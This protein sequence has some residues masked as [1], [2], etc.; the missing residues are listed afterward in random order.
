MWNIF[1]DIVLAIIVVGAVAFFVGYQAYDERDVEVG[2]FSRTVREYLY[3]AEDKA[4]PRVILAPDMEP[5]DIAASET[6]GNTIGLNGTGYQFSSDWFT[7][8]SPAWEAAL[9]EYVGKPN[10]QY[11]EVGV[12]EGRAAAWM[13]ENVL[14]HPTSH[15]TGIDIF[16]GELSQGSFVYLPESRKLYEDNMRVAGGEGRMTTI[17]D[18]SQTALRKLPLNYYDIIYI[19]GGHS[20]ASVLEDAI[21]AFRLLK[22]GGVMIFDDYR[23]FRTAPRTNRPGYAIDLFDEFF[24]EYFEMVHNQSQYILVKTGQDIIS[25][26]LDMSMASEDATL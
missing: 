26:G 24:G 17:V 13:F 7:R 12:Y 5:W 23:W 14:T 16:I 1:R 4:D 21:L 22:V 19:D 20:G 18:F 8:K 6:A 15:I 25:D 9:Q 3:N 2:S 10:V 11:L